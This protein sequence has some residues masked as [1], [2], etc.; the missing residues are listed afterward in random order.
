MPFAPLLGFWAGL[1]SLIP[2]VG[3]TIG[4]IPY[5]LVAFFQ[6]WPIGVAA[7]VFLI[8]YQQIENNVFQPIIHRYT[9]QL[10]PFWIILAVLV[11]ATILGFI[12]A[13]MAIPIAG[14]VQVVLQELWAWRQEQRTAAAHAAGRR[15]ARGHAAARH[16]ARTRAR[17]GAS[18]PAVDPR[19]A[20]L[21]ELPAVRERL[22]GLTAFA[23]G[24]ELA[25]ALTPS[26]DPGEVAGRAAETEEA[27]RLRDLGV[28]GPGGASD[29]RPATA[30]A[31][32]DAA[33][34][35]EALAEVLATVRIWL[36]ARDAVAG[37]GEEAP[38]LAAALAAPDVAAARRVEAALERAL[39]PRGGLLDTASPELASARRRLA[40][41]RRAAA[42]LLR[43]PRR[44]APLPPA[45]VVHH[46]AR[47][48]PGAGGQGVVALRGAGHRAR[49]L[50][51]RAR[52]SSSSPWSLSKQ[53]TGCGS[54]RPRRPRRRSASCARSR[55]WSARSAWPLDDLT[56][57]LAALDLAL[58]PGGPLA[59]V[60]R[61]AASSRR[62][63]STCA[64]PAIRCSTRR[65]PC[66]STCRSRACGR[67]WSPARTPAARPW[68]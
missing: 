27:L 67:W 66:R 18:L 26:A 65:R 15:A 11:G 14:I 50:R 45:G 52:R 35:A 44:P 10:N 64:R 32:R 3:A 54:W 24:R 25:L 62:P 42:D 38:R 40:A 30:A 36:E 37:H 63:R 8:V 7:I 46:R 58:A 68:R 47:R 17:R 51:L 31:A 56:A 57:A 29:L 20:E 49:Q 48:P 28:G 16:L 55:G 9:V 21:L 60:G 13:L 5:I 1:S 22:A 39:D 6:G 33:L 59:G 41:A 19:S 43:D 2:L 12:G 53:T 61:A 34:E 23:G 4:G